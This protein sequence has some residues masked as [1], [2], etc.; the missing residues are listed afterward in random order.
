MV[1]VSHSAAVT[2][3]I[4]IIYNINNNDDAHTKMTAISVQPV[5]K[6]DVEVVP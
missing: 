6:Y 4:I 5:R 1:G 3:S 2:V